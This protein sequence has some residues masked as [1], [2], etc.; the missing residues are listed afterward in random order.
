MPIIGNEEI[1]ARVQKFK[2]F[3]SEGNIYI[4]LYEAL[5]G[6]PAHKFIAVPNLLIKESDKKYFGVGDSKKEALM[7]C[8]KKIK[9]VP[10][11]EIISLD[12]LK[13]D[14]KELRAVRDA[15]RAS[16]S[17]HSI[18]KLPRIFSKGSKETQE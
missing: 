3:R 8:L 2:L 4:D 5:L 16:G 9:E 15:E 11:N 7:D 10:L 13:E 6:K 12:A 14:E 17:S 1:L 18:W